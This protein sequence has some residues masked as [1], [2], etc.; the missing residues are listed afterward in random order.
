[1][2]E[3]S[4]YQSTKNESAESVDN[5]KDKKMKT[6]YRFILEPYNGISSRHNCPQCE[7]K[8][9][10]SRY[11]DTEK[12]VAFPNHV[13]RCNREEKCAYHFT[14]KQY[15]EQNPQKKADVKV[16]TSCANRNPKQ[17]SKAINYIDKLVVNR[18]LT[19]Y[20]Q[21]KLC[22]FLSFQFG[23][24][25]ALELMQRYQV[26]TANLWNGATIF[27]QTDKMGKVRTGKIMLYNPISGKRIKQPH[28]HISWV[29]SLLELKDFNL[30]Q[31]FF[32]EHLLPIEKSLPVGIVESEKS[33]LIA[34]YYIPQYRWI[35]SGGKHGCLNKDNLEVLNGRKVV[36]FPDLGAFNEWNLKTI[37]MKEAGIEVK[38]FDYLEQNATSKQRNEGYDIADFLLQTKPSA[39]ILQM[40]IEKNPTLKI[41][42]ERF[43]LALDDS[44]KNN[45]FPRNFKGK[46]RGI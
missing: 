16:N 37:R 34:S 13:G 29:H 19:Q 43:D 6:Y 40:M 11:I 45:S 7:Q 8:R 3:H 17:I 9:C 4:H 46:Q 25:Q 30:K 10:F 15:F 20:P 2:T 44:S 18:S 27:W 39:S 5:S 14:P 26:G 38:V 31:C 21:N 1:M 28:N 23:H 35:A 22:Q 36:L 33:A 41:L 12:E 24:K 32:G 42:I